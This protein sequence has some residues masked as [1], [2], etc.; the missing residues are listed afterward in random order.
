MKTGTWLA[1]CA[2]T[3]A[4]VGFACAQESGQ[5]ANMSQVTVTFDGQDP[6]R[7]TCA[8]TID[9]KKAGLDEIGIKPEDLA[10]GIIC[11]PGD[12]DGNGYLDFAFFGTVAGEK[13][14]KVVFFK[15]KKAI[16][17]VVLKAPGLQ[18]YPAREK[19]GKHGEPATDRDAL[20]SPGADGVVTLYMYDADAKAWKELKYTLTP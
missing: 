4:V 2:L 10:K 11:I 8:G 3:L 16:R 18:F 7:P 19:A 1:A 17:G 9:G 14:A 13:V 15:E 6:L 12:F 5:R 20:A